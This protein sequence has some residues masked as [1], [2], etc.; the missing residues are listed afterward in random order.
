MQSGDV[1]NPFEQ[2]ADRFKLNEFYQSR[3][4]AFARIGISNDINEEAKTVDTTYSVA[5]GEKAYFGR[6]EISGNYETQDDVIRRELTVHDNELFD[7]VKLR[8][9]QQNIYRLG[10]F[11]QQEGISITQKAGEEENTLDYNINLKEGQTGSFNGSVTYSGYSGLAFAVS[12]SKK[13]LFGTG[14]SLTLSL[15]KGTG[16]ESSNSV[17]LTSPYWLD[18]NFTNSTQ[19]FANV[20]DE[21]YYTARRTGFDFGLTYPVWKNWYAFGNLN[22][23]EEAYSD[24]DVSNDALVYLDNATS[25]SSRSIRLG[26]KYSTVNNTLFPTDGFETS[27]SAEYFGSILGGTVDYQEYVLSA[28]YYKTLSEGGRVV[29]NA[30]INWSHLFKTD[31]NI[32][33]PYD[34]RYR[35]GGITTVRGFDWYEIE[36]PSSYGEL[37]GQTAVNYAATLGAD[38]DYFKR[39]RGGI[40]Q[41]ILNLNLLFPLTREGQNIRG[42][43]FFD[44]GNVWSEDTMYDLGLT[45][46][47]YLYFRKSWGFGLR[48]LTPMGVFRFEYGIKLD[49]K[50]SESPSKF[51]FHISGLF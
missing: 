19:I 26:G 29:F 9:S 46:K 38:E 13:N 7:G 51:D 18:T 22:W 31:P 48:L 34:R 16:E 24:V 32:E 4:Y 36:G 10:F 8:E 17:A 11:E 40:D 28:K 12:V 2:N 43:V 25:N 39:H 1:F 42:V 15:E 49:K 33:I 50:P 27:L 35:I 41:K 30:G 23:T 37:N 20:V 21:D 3:G 45:E 44:M 14:R 5:R 47:D 6:I